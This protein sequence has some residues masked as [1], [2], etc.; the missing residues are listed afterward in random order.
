MLVGLYNTTLFGE[1]V[2]HLAN[3]PGPKGRSV[4]GHRQI[5]GQTSQGTGTSAVVTTLQT[6]MQRRIS[7]LM[8]IR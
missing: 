4:T 1:L 5:S 3:A 6:T 7:M 8:G 2:G